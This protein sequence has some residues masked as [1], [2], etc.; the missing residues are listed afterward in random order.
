MSKYMSCAETAKLVRQSLKE[1]FPGVKF[2]VKSSVYSGGA[3]IT[4]RYEDGPA[5]KIVESV[6]KRFQG[7][8]FDGMIDYKGSNKHT[9]DGEIVSFGADFIFVNRD[10]SAAQVERAIVFLLNKYPN[11]NFGSL[12]AQEMVPAFQSG[13]LYNVFPIGG[14]WSGN[15]SL[16]C[17]VNATLSKFSTVAAP[18]ASATPERVS[19]YGDDGCGRGTVGMPGSN[20][21]EQC[22]KAISA[23]QE[24]IAAE[25][26]AEVPKF[27]GPVSAVLQ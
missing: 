15:N 16:Q 20:G 2:S 11:N 23:R 3:S 14:E 19:F 22:Y 1:S 9:L 24:Q 26:A 6:A 17:M 25:K 5:A 27:M 18:A 7:G 21:G 4:V 12:S 10:H 13:K 8:Y